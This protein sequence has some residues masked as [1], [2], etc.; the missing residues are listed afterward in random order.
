MKTIIK[1]LIA[2]VILTGCFNVGRALMDEYRFEDAVHERLLFDPRMT[3]T[4]IVKMV[5]DTASQF[6]VPIT[7]ND[8]EIREQGPDIRVD[9]QY[10]MDVVVIPGVFTYPWTFTPSA[11]TR[12][13]V[14]NRRK[15]S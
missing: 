8:I 11:S 3:D 6:D 13:L 12:M 10:T 5:L 9:M 7:A 14:G 2:V 15:P 1:I 4:E